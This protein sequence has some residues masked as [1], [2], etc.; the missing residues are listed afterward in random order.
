MS[1]TRFWRRVCSPD[2][3][4]GDNEQ[5]RTHQALGRLRQAGEL[6]SVIDRGHAT[7]R[8]NSGKMLAMAKKTSCCQRRPRCRPALAKE[9]RAVRLLLGHTKIE[10]TAR[11]LGIEVDDALAIAEQVDVGNNPGRAAYAADPQRPF[12]ARNYIRSGL[13]AWRVPAAGLPASPSEPTKAM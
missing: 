2:T 7:S 12:R 1:G 13:S 4:T 11:Y 9:L 8:R 5:P 3:Q 6:A 10:R